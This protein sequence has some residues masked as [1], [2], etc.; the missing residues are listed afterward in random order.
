MLP[1]AAL[2]VRSDGLYPALCAVALDGTPGKDAREYAGP[3]PVVAHPP[4]AR[5]GNLWWSARHLGKGLG[6]DDG[7]FA[8][9][10]ASV[11]RW[12]GVLEH[13]AGSRAWPRFGLVKPSKGGGWTR[14]PDAP[15]EYTTEVYQRNY[16]HRAHKRTWLV[17]VGDAPP[18]D[19]DWSPPAAP[20]AYVTA[21]RP[22]AELRALGIRLMGRTERE[23]TPPAFAEAL[24]RLAL[25]AGGAP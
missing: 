14:S 16:G 10:V 13:P 3:Y 17:Y 8:A 6:D 22:M 19:L 2:F 7:C 25:R 21:D 15:R 1:V 5:W 18:T 12:G 11:R 20:E 24:L 4:C 9:A 23:A